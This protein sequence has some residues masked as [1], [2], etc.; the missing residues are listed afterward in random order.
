MRVLL[1]V[2]SY[3]PSTKSSARLVHDLAVEFSRQGHDVRLAAPD[4]SLAG[5]VETSRIDGVDVLRV[6][7]PRFKS[8]ARPLRGFHEARL[9]SLL[10]RRGKRFFREHPCDLVVYYSPTI[11]F[12]PLV[13]RLKKL[14]GASSYLILR[15]IFPQWAVDAGVLRRGRLPWRYFRRMELLQYDVADRIG[16]QSP[17]NLAYF[18]EQGWSGKYKLEVLWH[19]SPS[20]HE[21]LPRTCLRDTLGLAGK[22]VFFYGGNIGVAQDMDNVIR[23]ASS[24][25][26]RPDAHFLLVGEG[27]EVAR[28]K[29]SVRSLGLTNVEFHPPLDQARYLATLSEFDIGL[30]TLDAGLKTQNFPGK[31]LGY[32]YFALPTLASINAGNDLRQVIERNQAGLVSL[33]GDDEAFRNNALKLLDQPE[34][35]RR[36]GTAGREFLETEYSTGRAV[37]QIIRGVRPCTITSHDCF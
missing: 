21:G 4:D 20:K 5:P 22:T 10:W 9:S 28:L 26:D 2:D 13:R 14:W 25:T 37:R 23:L 24:L 27:S 36:L 33:N 15:D 1:L 32:M 16:V 7:S 30:I 35:R 11:F 18:D 29:E 8:A 17:A 6:R 19:W 3:L 12:G 34:L 31:M